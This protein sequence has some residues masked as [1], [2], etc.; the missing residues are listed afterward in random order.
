M[1]CEKCGH[2]IEDGKLYCEKCGNEIQ[3]V[4][5]FDVL[6]ED[7]IQ[8]NLVDVAEHIDGK[9]SSETVEKQKTKEFEIVSNGDESVSDEEQPS[10]EKLNKE[11][12]NAKSGGSSKTRKKT[13]SV[14]GMTVV[15]VVVCCMIFGI[16]FAYFS[17]NSSRRLSEIA[18]SR[19]EVEDYEGAAK[20]L[21]KVVNKDKD[22]MNAK[23]LLCKNYYHLG[24]FDDSIKI[25]EEMYDVNSADENVVEELLKNY[26]AKGDFDSVS[27]IFNSNDLPELKEEYKEYMPSEVVFSLTEEIYYEPQYLALKAQDGGDVYY[28]LDGSKADTNS[29]KFETPIFI[30]DGVTVVNAM[31]VNSNGI[32]SD[33][34]VKT[35]TVDY[36]I[37]DSVEVE[38]E[39]GSF[40]T[41]K[42]IKV[43]VPD[44]CVCYY[45]VNGDDPTEES[46]E[47]AGPFPMYIG[48]H[49]LRFVAVSDKGVLS[50]IKEQKYTLDLVNF[51]D[52]AEAKDKLKEKLSSKGVL[53]DNYIYRCEQAYSING[54]NY[55]IIN[56]YE[57]PNEEIKELEE[58]W[59]NE[60]VNNSYVMPE[61]EKNKEIEKLAKV[62]TGNSYAVDVLDGLLFETERNT[63]TGEI[64]LSGM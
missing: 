2:E 45:T 55:Y 35:F 12:K 58:K 26:I 52:M 53:I 8:T 37:P 28:T 1:V 13:I 56:E 43:S 49:T 21:E 64:K 42:L 15:L 18:L 59:H 47:Y 33:N 50:D 7:K 36:I 39:G 17:L 5:E 29:T 14:F 23:L 27:V 32:E 25:L 9:V 48:A 51:V 20:L 10:D 62:R 63:E 61:K 34:F 41:P 22:D 24:R 57:R 38:T 4:P 31:C 40:T 46:I 16:I 54:K 19:Y 3:M 60:E 11:N 30:D 44:N 6:I